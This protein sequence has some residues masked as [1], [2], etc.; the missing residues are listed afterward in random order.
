MGAATLA[1][2]NAGCAK[3]ARAPDMRVSRDAGCD[4][5]A[6]WTEQVA[7]TGRLR[8][9]S[10]SVDDMAAL[11]QELGAPGDLASC[12]TSI[13]AGYGWKAMSRRRILL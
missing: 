11:K 6:V 12:H 13:I 9:T 1:G 4:C 10:V 7:A 2:L 3:D 8:P 5:C